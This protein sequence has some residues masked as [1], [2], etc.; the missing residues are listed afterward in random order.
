MTAAEWR[1]ANP[2]KDLSDESVA[3]PSEPEIY[4]KNESLIGTWLW[5]LLGNGKPSGDGSCTFN[6][7]GSGMY[8]LYSSTQLNHENIHAAS[9]CS[10]RLT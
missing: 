10:D 4:P 7:D 5:D 1:K 8:T 6:P 3:A 9:I 2:D